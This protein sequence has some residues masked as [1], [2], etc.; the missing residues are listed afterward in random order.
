MPIINR[1]I[2]S[3]PSPIIS[4]TYKNTTKCFYEQSKLF[5]AQI[6]ELY[7]DLWPMVTAIQ[8]LMWQVSGYYHMTGITQNAKLNRKFVDD[9]DVTN[10]PNLYRACLERTMDD[11]KYNL[12]KN[13][14]TNMFAVYEGWVD[15]IIPTVTTRN[16]SSKS[17][18]FPGWWQASLS[19]IQAGHDPLIESTYY[20]S[21]KLVNRNYN[22]GHLDNY[23]KVYRYFK[24]C[25]NCIIHNG[26]V[27]DIKLVNAYNDIIGLTCAD[28]DVVEFPQI[29]PIRAIGDKTV[30]HLRGVVG[31]SQILIKIV[32]TLDIEFI[33][34]ENSLQ[35]YLGKIKEHNPNPLYPSPDDGKR[36]KMV[37]GISRRSFF[38]EPIFSEDL[39]T[40]YKRNG[41]LRI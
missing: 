20:D 14:L 26:G 18:Q 13:L 6:T 28:I 21:Y 24:E 25:R 9:D 33:K 27:A 11:W 3:K 22:Y 10:R 29:E 15:M 17:L 12:A 37:E 1:E 36:K 5:E 31:F 40:L 30:L 38:I 8:N 23:F 39:C 32:S 16:I 41:I 35:Y 34:A 7:D 4:G 19:T 2:L